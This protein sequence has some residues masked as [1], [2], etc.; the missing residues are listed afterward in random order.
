MGGKIQKR[1]GK[2]PVASSSI[3]N[4]DEEV[5]KQRKVIR[6]LEEENLNHGRKT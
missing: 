1:E 3:S 6:N 2:A 5:G 4:W